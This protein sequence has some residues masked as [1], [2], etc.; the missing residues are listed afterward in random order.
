V[1]VDRIEER[2][3]DDLLERSARLR[4]NGGEFRA[5]FAVPPGL[6]PPEPDGSPFLAVSLLPAMAFH[7][8]LV[9]DAPVSALLARSAEEIQRTYHGWDPSLRRAAVAVAEQ[10]ERPPAGERR[11][12]FF[13][14]G[15]DSLFTATHPRPAGGPS[16][17]VNCSTFDPFEDERSREEQRRRARGAAEAVGLPLA[18]V[19]MNVRELTERVI[20]FID[21]HGAVLAALAQSLSGGLRELVVASSHAAWEFNAWGSNPVL[22]SLF[23]TEAMRVVHDSVAYS[24]V[25]KAAWL[26]RERPDL[27]EHLEVCQARHAP[28]NCG[29]CEKCVNT[30]A[31]FI[32]AGVPGAVPG[33]PARP[34]A[35][36]IRTWRPQGIGRRLHWLS[37]LAA[38]PPGE[39]HAELRGAISHALRR[40]ARPTL[41]DRARALREWRE[42]IR[43]DPDPVTVLHGSSFAGN[44][45]NTLIQLLRYGR[46]FHEHRPL[47]AGDGA[48]PW[49][50]LDGARTGLVRGLDLRAGRHVYAVGAAPRG[51]LVGELGA[52]ERHELPGTR[53]VWLTAD[54]RLALAPEPVPAAPGGARAR[55]RWALAPLGWRESEPGLRARALGGR[56]L[57]LARRR[58]TPRATSPGFEPVTPA[59]WIHTSDGAGRVPLWAATHAATGDQLLTRDAGEAHDMGFEGAELLGWLSAE[60]PVTGSLAVQRRDVPWASRWGRRA[61]DV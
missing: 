4:W 35:E 56:A 3:L 16:I 34:D 13:S 52:L 45:T 60:A 19:R 22:D 44:W 46:S 51:Q 18:D 36:L 11:G 25:D 27:L 57:E 17:L 1:I 37:T 32:A 30:A 20:D 24:R 41:R 38:I 49:E 39:E 43:P 55:L 14:R 9:V 26:A 5:R 12:A 58:Q 6:A 15:I 31:T 21:L 10:H 29:R 48:E 59:G 53:P 28:G 23:S 33:L 54:R 47:Q 42:G 61:R 50:P 40:A 2:E 8:D 7:E